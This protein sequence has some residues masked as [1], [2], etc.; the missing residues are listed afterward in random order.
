MEAFAVEKFKVVPPSAVIIHLAM[1]SG[2][3][4]HSLAKIRVERK[5]PIENGFEVGGV[6]ALSGAEIIGHFEN[7]GP[8][9]V[10]YP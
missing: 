5:V 9:W 8:S 1:S 3:Q 4:R 2:N 6:N 7:N 10:W